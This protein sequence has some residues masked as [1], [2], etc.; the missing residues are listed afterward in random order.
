[1]AT[2]TRSSQ[3][4]N[5][6]LRQDDRVSPKASA[7]AQV[8]LR[9]D[10]VRHSLSHLLAAA[11]LK[12]FSKAKL[13]IGPI[14]ED[15]FYYDFLLP[16]TLAP[17]DL[18]EFEKTMREFIS[19]KLPFKGEKIT[20]A[21]A[22]KLFKDQPFK[23]ELIKEYTNP[24]PGVKK[25]PL[26][27]YITGKVPRKS[28]PSSPRYRS[29]EAGPRQSAFVDLCAGDHVKNTKEI[30]PDAFKLDKIAGAYWRGSEKNP[31]LQRIYGLAFQT[32]KELDNYLKLL[33]E[34]RK[35]DHR[36]LGK[37]L[38]L[39]IFSEEVGPG[40]PLY[41]PRGNQIRELI[42]DYITKLKTDHGYSFVWT[43]HLAKETL[44]KK[45]GHLGKYEA[46]L[47]AIQ[48]EDE[49]LIVKPMNCPHHFEIYLSEPRSYRDLPFRI[50]ENATDYRNEKSGE[51]NGL[52]RVRSLTQDD[53]H[54]AVRHN[55]IMSEIDMIFGIT[56]EVYKTFGFKKFRVRVSTRGDK[57]KEKYFGNDK[58]WK[59]AESALLK[60]VKRWGVP[61]FVGVGEAAFYGPKID[62][63]VEDV[64][65]REWQLTTVQLDY[66]Q[67][68]NFDMTYI[69]EKGKKARPAILHV[70]ILGSFDRFFGVI[71]EHFAG[72]F[73]LWLSPTQAEIINVGS[74]QRKYAKEVYEKLA[75]VGVRA[76]LSDENLTVSKRIRDAEIMKIPYI[77][78]V[79]EK[80][81]KNGTVNVRHYRHGQEGEVKIDKFVEK[82][83]REREDK[84]I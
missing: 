40:L 57:N 53:T 3:V 56:K 36:T 2:K 60:A 45:S 11:V 9:R 55:Q 42:L 17:D 13:G 70:A 16:R 33:E 67:P 62:I 41:T 81:Q 61:Y 49:R 51:L 69:N 74:A 48:T 34:A 26:T 44:Y 28:A 31:Q 68:E 79:G 39:F 6:R 80:E 75:G 72:A 64:L 4:E 54:H 84:T 20:P 82:I 37:Q 18:K 5:I 8:S 52:F 7:V 66:F 58:L 21:Q 15:G 12:K 19:Q 59:T 46:M 10:K 78:V 71:I 27:I 77:L 23:L 47:P 38:K 43:P 83:N 30:N 14:I 29:G 24:P 1:M 73:P 25:R 50:A 35:R 32:K 22:K 65:G 63:L 76:K